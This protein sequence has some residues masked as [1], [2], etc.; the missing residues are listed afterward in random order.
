MKRKYELLVVFAVS[1]VLFACMSVSVFADT[2]EGYS[3]WIGDT[4][5]TDTNKDKI[6]HKGGGVVSF[7]PATNTLTLNNVQLSQYAVHGEPG[8]QSDPDCI[9]AEGIDLTID[10]IGDNQI[11]GSS[12]ADVFGIEVR[13]GGGISADVIDCSLT[14]RGEKD[15]TLTIDKVNHGFSC[16]GTI[17]IKSGDIKAFPNVKVDGSS[18]V[19][20]GIS[21]KL[22]IE[23]GSLDIQSSGNGINTGNIKITG[24]TTN[25][26]SVYS[27]IDARNDVSVSGG[28]LVIRCYN[29]KGIEATGSIAISGGSVDIQALDNAM[30]AREGS[31]EITG[32]T[33]KAKTDDQSSALY[34]V[35]SISVTQGAQRV[36]AVTNGKAAIYSLQD[37]TITNPIID[38]AVAVIQQYDSGKCVG[39][40]EEETF[41]PAKTVI[42]GCSID[43]AKVVLSKT[44]FVY[45]G[46]TQMPVIRTIG[47]SELVADTDY[48]AEWSDPVSRDVG[49]FTV[50]VTGKGNYVGTTKATYTISPKGTSLK[51]L[52]KAKKAATIKWNKQA[53]KMSKSRVT[54]YQILLATNSKFT[55]GKKTVNVK[56]YSKTSKKVKKLKGGKKYYVKIR[57]YMT[58]GGKNC[59]SPWSKVKTVKTGK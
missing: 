37:L 19:P 21:G 58:V 41:I 44:S 17:D 53:M 4:Q 26:T 43:N 10:L 38:P 6:P 3:L 1:M 23:G 55:K 33:V 30:K 51:K 45:N 2:A 27:G 25:V 20:T 54:G 36:E 49:T 34:A 35:R 56:G 59:Y 16:S 50:T 9:F 47:G 40:I 5:V 24:G 11:I 12:D 7:D 32:G 29:E 52:K 8:Y 18:Y 42:I 57:T 22:T 13:S 15:S 31:I 39:T 48:T 28:D 14:I 46:K